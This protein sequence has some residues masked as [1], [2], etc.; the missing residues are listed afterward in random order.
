MRWRRRLCLRV[1]VFPS[2]GKGAATRLEPFFS[3]GSPPPPHTQRRPTFAREP[4][5]GLQ[6]DYLAEKNMANYVE[7][8]L[9]SPLSRPGKY[10]QVKTRL[11]EWVLRS[12]KVLVTVLCQCPRSSRLAG[13]SL[14][15]ERN[16][17][18]AQSL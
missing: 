11:R 8:L 1:S 7:G 2:S 12:F 9:A 10:S 13:S 18:I 16:L 4:Y 3:R 14:I 15:V 17:E 5:N 6:Y